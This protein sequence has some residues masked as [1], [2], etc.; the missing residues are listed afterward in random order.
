MRKYWWTVWIEVGIMAV[1]LILMYNFA[2]GTVR[3]YLSP[4]IIEEE[5]VGERTDNAIKD[6]MEKVEDKMKIRVDYE[7]MIFDYANE[8]AQN[9]MKQS[10]EERNMESET[11]S[12]VE[13]TEDYRGTQDT[14]E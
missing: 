8:Y 14:E 5:E 12:T 6:I 1:L 7:N 10:H 3:Q 4:Y 11:F 13:E 9:M 2:V